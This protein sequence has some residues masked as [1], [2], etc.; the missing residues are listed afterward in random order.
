MSHKRT[1]LDDIIERAE[2]ER[3]QQAQTQPAPTTITV[4][5][6]P[7]GDFIRE[8]QALA[9]RWGMTPQQVITR[10]V[11]LIYIDIYKDLP[12]RVTP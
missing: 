6:S 8:V 9:A 3:L 5:L 10:C 12:W 11:D 4:H 7:D 2:A 1:D